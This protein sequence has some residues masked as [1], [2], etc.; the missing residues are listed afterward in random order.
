[1]K[2]IIIKDN[3]K[4]GLNIIER[5]TGKNPTLP[6]LNNI[7][8]KVKQNFLTLVG[9]DLEIG[10]EYRTL[11]KMEQEGQISI[12]AKPFS[13]LIN[14]LVDEDM[15]IELK[16]K[17]D[18]LIV[19]GKNF[20]SYIKGLSP[21]DFPIIPKVK[22]EKDFIEINSTPFLNGVLK[23]LDFCS[24]GQTHPELCGVYFNIQKEK[25]EMVSTDSFRLAKKNMYYENKINKGYS[26]ILPQKAVKEVANIISEISS[27][28][29]KEFKTKIYF[30]PNQLFFEF[31]SEDFSFPQFCL[32][33]RLIE[34]TFPNYQEIIPKDYKTQ[35]V[36]N[37][38]DFLNKIKTASL[39]SGKTNRVNLKVDPSKNLITF[40]AQDPDIGEHKSSMDGKVGGEKAD[41]SFNFKFLIDGV[42][43]L[44]DGSVIFELNGE[45]GPA[46]LKSTKD[47]D[48]IYIL[49]PIKS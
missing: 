20:K 12:P 29:K 26:F 35:I 34:G 9:T 16:R 39:F 48:Y 18:T 36:L 24:I 25:M 43:N 17:D 8:I 41:I 19:S 15:Q 14:S 10:M 33:S 1:M 38:E 44:E 28:T 42:S 45:D 21:E 3:L 7:L 4:K 30:E 22:N 49:M 6:V 27:Q 31:L 11:I 2:L 47:T 5:V 13:S 40:F 32:T 46:L 37:K 23:V